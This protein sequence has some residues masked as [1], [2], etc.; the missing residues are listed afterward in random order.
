M[1]LDGMGGYRTIDS[2]T[3]LSRWREAG[4][5]ESGGDLDTALRAAGAT[6]ARFAVVGSAVGVRGDV[7]LLSEI[8]DLDTG[9]EIGSGQVRGSVGD[10]MPLIDDLSLETMRLLLAGGSQELGT[11]RNLA[12]LTTGSVEALRAYLEGERFYRRGEFAPAADAYQ[13]ALIADSAF[14][15]AI[16]RVSDTYGWLEDV[17]SDIAL[18]AS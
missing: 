4:G 3:M 8:Y 15:L 11:T 6:G 16:Y 10:P 14:A 13:R 2:R 12:D 7:T 17:S 9:R 1:N 18:E 5:G